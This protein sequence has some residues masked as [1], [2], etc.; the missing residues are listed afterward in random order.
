MPRERPSTAAL[1]ALVPY[2][3]A[4]TAIA[5]GKDLSSSEVLAVA[6]YRSRRVEEGRSHKY[7]EDDDSQHSRE[8]IDVWYA[9]ATYDT[10]YDASRSYRT[11]RGDDT[12]AIIFPNDASTTLQERVSASLQEQA[13]STLRET[14]ADLAP[15]ASELHARRAGV[16][17][18]TTAS[19]P[20]AAAADPSDDLAAGVAS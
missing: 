5:A 13:S 7:E 15:G 11:E 20:N 1:N 2:V 10:L 6:E 4:I 14:G 17:F 3:D 12:Y 16:R 9:V 8:D 18:A 19:P